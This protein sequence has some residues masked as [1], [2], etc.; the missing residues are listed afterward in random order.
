MQK[1][2]MIL[3]TFV[4]MICTLFAF[5]CVSADFIDDFSQEDYEARGW[6]GRLLFGKPD[7]EYL[8]PMPDRL[9]IHMP[10]LN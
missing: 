3:L 10:D 1:N 6:S 2:N 5:G 4:S 8:Y 9:S 7:L